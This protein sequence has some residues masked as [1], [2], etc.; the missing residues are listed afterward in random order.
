MQ[1]IVRIP[2]NRA[3][4]DVQADRSGA[5]ALVVFIVVVLVG[6]AHASASASNLVYCLLEA[7]Q[8]L[9]R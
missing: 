8:I 3:E 9:T 5:M 7:T 6:A 4:A 1:L 2:T